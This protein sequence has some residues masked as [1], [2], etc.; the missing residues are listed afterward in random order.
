MPLVWPRLADVQRRSRRL[1]R[2]VDGWSKRQQAGTG[3]RRAGTEHVLALNPQLL[4]LLCA[5]P[6]SVDAP[7]M[8]RRLGAHQQGIQQLHMRCAGP[9]WLGTAGRI[10][11]LLRGSLTSLDLF[12]P[13]SHWTLLPPA[14]CWHPWRDQC[15]WRNST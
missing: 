14:A 7:A 5:G 15:N 1:F 9:H 6:D 8:M 11:S 3:G 4:P 12:T 10:M 13:A 2:R